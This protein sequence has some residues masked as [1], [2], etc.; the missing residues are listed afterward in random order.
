[1]RARLSPCMSSQLA[2]QGVA[3]DRV[4]RG[5]VLVMECFCVSLESAATRDCSVSSRHLLALRGGDPMLVTTL[6]WLVPAHFN[7]C[8][9]VAPWS[10]REFRD[11]SAAAYF[12]PSSNEEFVPIDSPPFEPLV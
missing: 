3:M 9:N 1:M 5:L 11:S 6:V 12:F 8:Q 7:L 4:S 2:L 10:G